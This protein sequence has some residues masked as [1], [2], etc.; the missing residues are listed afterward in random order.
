[1][2][3]FLLLVNKQGQARLTK[4]YELMD[5]ADRVSLEADITRKVLARTENQCSFIDYKDYKVVYRRYASLF[6]IVGIDHEENELAILEFIHLLVETFD[7]YFNK[8][9]ELDI[10][11]NLEKAHMMLDEMV[12]NGYI[13]ETNKARIL[14]PIQ[15]IDRASD[16]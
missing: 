1:M 9:C 12:T 3:K 6:F 4:Y 16:R 2:L 11:C 13:V 7:K 15:V 5:I 14:A 10:M 8:V